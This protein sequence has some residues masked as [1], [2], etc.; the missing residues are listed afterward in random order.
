MT[1]LTRKLS[2]NRSESDKHG[3]KTNFLNKKIYNSESPFINW[4][5]DNI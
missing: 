2:K 1:I 5:L 3:S 4:L